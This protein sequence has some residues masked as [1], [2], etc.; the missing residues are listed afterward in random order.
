MR[1]RQVEVAIGQ[2]AVTERGEPDAAPTVVLVHGYPDSSHLWGPVAD[3]LAADH[4]VV[5]YD[6][7]GA[8][9]SSAP[10]DR[11]G[12]HLRHLMDDLLAVVDATASGRPVHLV[13]HDWGAIQA[14]AAART[15]AVASRLASVTAMSAP[16]LEV[17]R[18]WLRTRLDE[19]DPAALWQVAGQ[20]GRS[21]YV[22]AFQ[23]PA[24]PELVVRRLLPATLRRGGHPSPSPTVVEDAVRGIELYRANGWGPWREPLGDLP[25]DLPLRV[26]TGRAD[27]F[28]SPR[29]F[30]DLRDRLG[31]PV[32]VIDGGHW[33][34]LTHP[35]AV[36]AQI[37]I[38]TE[39]DG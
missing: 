34:P 24:V 30:D 27:P 13:G 1:Q 4:H 6:V 36:A 37:R 21:W 16:G 8:G 18:W 39:V 11:S 38:A 15:P 35:E 31:I 25:E 7:R 14:F 3:Q 28:V 23:V 19:R 10:R 22:G 32:R 33:L 20:A 26:V 2:L 9:A 17:A 12:Y 5:T 29:V